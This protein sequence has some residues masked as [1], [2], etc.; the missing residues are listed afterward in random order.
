M[1]KNLKRIVA[2][3]VIFSLLFSTAGYAVTYPTDSKGHWAEEKIQKFVDSGVIEGYKDG[4]FKPDNF[5]TR[6]EFVT[7]INRYFEFEKTAA[8]GFTDIPKDAWYK[9]QI[10]KAMGEGYILGYNDNSFRP[11]E[12]ITRQEAAVIIAKLLKFE[13]TS[14]DNNGNNL[15][16]FNDSGNVPAW[17]KG[18]LNV[19]IR[20][21]LLKGYP[22]KTI[23]YQKYLTRAELLALLENIE[24]YTESTVATPEIKSVAVINGKITIELTKDAENLTAKDFEIEATLDGKDYD[25]NNLKFDSDKIVFTF[26]QITKTSKVQILEVTVRADSDKLE[27][28]ATDDIEI[29][30]KS[31]SSGSSDNGVNTAPSKP[32]I[33]RTPS[34]SVTTTD[35][36]T[37]TAVSTDAQGDSIT[38]IW[39]GKLTDGS[40]YP[41]G[42][43]IVTVKAVD[44]H[45][46]ES[47]QAAIVFFVTN[48]SSGE[49]GVMLTT[50]NSRIYENGIEG[51]TIT[52]FTFNV[53]SVSG[54]SGSDQAWVRG[55]NVNTQQWEYIPNVTGT[56]LGY[57]ANYNYTN[58]P[59][60]GNP[61]SI[62]NGVYL[63][64]T[65]DPGTYSRLELFYY[66]SHCMYGNSR[67]TY[68]ID[69]EFGAIDPDVPDEAAPVAS[70]VAISGATTTSAITGDLLTGSYNY[71]DINGDLEG[72]L[73]ENY[74]V[75]STSDFQWY[76]SD[77]SAGTNKTPITG[78]TS[79]TYTVSGDDAGK[80][81]TFEVTPLAVTG[82]EGTLIGDP[83]ESAPLYVINNKADIESLTIT[84]QT[85]EPAEIDAVNHTVEV[86]VAYGTDVT[87]LTPA[88]TVSAGATINPVSESVQD[89]TAPVD[90]TVTAEDGVTTQL[91]TVTVSVALPNTETDILTF[92]LPEQTGPATIDSVNHTVT[93][94]VANGTVITALTPTITVSAAATINPVSESAQDFTAPVDY[95]VTAEDGTTTQVWTVTITE[96]PLVN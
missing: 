6:A 58:I 73:D 72:Y 26:T 65:I 41:L 44:E 27:G 2:V 51:A 24:S 64:G 91:W 83:A 92:S 45:G 66:A 55:L 95:T 96:Q 49:G 82:I 4:T 79:L 19:L 70:N 47:D 37:I 52:G 53:P 84:S 28:N 63:E 13:L 71:S 48:P 42:K 60:S 50:P 23:G 75:V 56:T 40:T 54:H 3:L 43:N 30:K 46:A 22:G 57:D 29:D 11:N 10:E 8:I 88:I 1:K 77:D 90:Y 89:F 9:L 7:I 14:D 16:E 15:G 94:E 80:Y 32:V 33:T 36:V 74:D 78:A 18:P 62:A 34:G 17:S 81:L 39:E 76:R 5:V 21:S 87:A 35:Q 61:V 59:I 85:A 69:Y 86:E 12:Y 20:H 31:S 93:L 38:Y 25:L 67:I 68:T